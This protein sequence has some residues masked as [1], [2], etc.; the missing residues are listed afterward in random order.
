MV[1]TAIVDKA[2]SII[3]ALALLVFGFIFGT[4]AGRVVYHLVRSLKIDDILVRSGVAEIFAKS[5][6]TLN[7]AGL[8]GWLVKAFFVVVFAI[9][10][11]DILGLDRVNEFLQVVV[12]YIPDVIA[13]VLI[14]LIAS[15]ASD[16]VGKVLTGTTTA[17]GATSAH[18]LSVVARYAIWIFAFIAA[19]SQVGIAYDLM[20]T[21]FMGI[22]AML[23]LAGGLSFGLGGKE[24]AADFIKK[25]RS[26]M[27]EGRRS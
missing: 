21:L 8:F 7:V 16:I 10:A 27:R 17:M 18:M 26:E 20:K 5:G 13:A 25:V 22:V 2:P 11:F 15:V 3:V 12:G 4:A 24:A 23:A 19:L 14:L 6:H 9:V 1:G